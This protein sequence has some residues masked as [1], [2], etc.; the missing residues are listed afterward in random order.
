L[1]HGVSGA[2]SAAS[3][4]SSQS[5]VPAIRSPQARLAGRGFTAI[6]VAWL[7]KFNTFSMI[8]ISALIVF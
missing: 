2:I 1:Y 3:R 8:A 4:D 7:A 6:I 5:P